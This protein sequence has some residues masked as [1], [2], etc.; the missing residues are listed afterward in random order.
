MNIEITFI[1]LDIINGQ[2]VIII[3]QITEIVK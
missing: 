1:E 3:E 2:E